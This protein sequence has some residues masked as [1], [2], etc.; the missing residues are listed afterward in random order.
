[1]C[2]HVNGDAIVCAHVAT[3]GEKSKVTIPAGSLDAGAN[4][5]L[6]LTG[7]VKGGLNSLSL[8]VTNLPFGGSCGITPTVGK[9]MV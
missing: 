9:F 3:V 2:W 8:A 4:Y 7:S 1:M 6:S 5:T